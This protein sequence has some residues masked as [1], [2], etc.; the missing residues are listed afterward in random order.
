MSYDFV[1][2]DDFDRPNSSTL[3]PDW[4][5]ES[6]SPPYLTIVDGH[7]TGGLTIAGAAY[8]GRVDTGGAMV[9]T[10][11]DLEG[12]GVALGAGIGDIETYAGE[13]YGDPTW[14]GGSIYIWPGYRASFTVSSVDIVQVG[15]ELVDLGGPYPVATSKAPETLAHIDIALPAGPVELAIIVNGDEISAFVNGTVVLTASGTGGLGIGGSH[16]A[17]WLLDAAADSAGGQVEPTFAVVSLNHPLN[18]RLL[19]GP[20]LSSPPAA[21]VSLNAKLLDGAG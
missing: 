11:I 12:S 18:D 14:E 15:M 4:L 13:P 5:N 19:D 2:L 20:P 7:A 9:L 8:I 10:G 3:G 6:A 1:L 16:V 17:F 21:G